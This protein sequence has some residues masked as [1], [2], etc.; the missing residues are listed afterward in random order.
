[1]SWMTVNLKKKKKP[2]NSS[3]I[4]WQHQKA[5]E[6]QNPSCPPRLDQPTLS[7]RP[8]PTTNCFPKP[9]KS[10]QKA[11]NQQKIPIN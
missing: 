3:R 8:N 4:S 6:Y 2:G 5:K 1:M 11:Q 10:K 9:K 7:P